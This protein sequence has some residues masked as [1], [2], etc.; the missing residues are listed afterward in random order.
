MGTLSCVG[1]FAP[2]TIRCQAP[3]KKAGR[4]ALDI[5]QHGEVLVRR[6]WD[7][8]RCKSA[9]GIGA[10]PARAASARDAGSGNY[11]AGLRENQ[12]RL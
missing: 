3:A 10:S 9:T 11:T 4:D 1:R 7:I 6:T 5:D 8:G 2:E 12:H